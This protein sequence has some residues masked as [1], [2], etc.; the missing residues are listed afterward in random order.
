MLLFADDTVLFSYTTQGMQL[1]LDKLCTYC[2][3][4]NITVNVKKTSVIIFNL[5]PEQNMSIYFMIRAG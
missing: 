1:L 3:Q 4:W 2:K 5:E